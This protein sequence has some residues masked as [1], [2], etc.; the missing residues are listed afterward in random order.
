VSRRLAVTGVG[1]L[2]AAGAGRECLLCATASRARPRTFTPYPG[3]A[4][5]DGVWAASLPEPPVRELLPPRGT[6]A[7]SVEG[8]ALLC[9]AVLACREAGLPVPT[10][11]PRPLGDRCAGVALGTTRA[12]L[13]D[14]WRLFTEGVANGPDGMSPALGPRTG[15]NTPA[16][17][18][19]IML[20]AA[21][22]HL[23]VSSGAASAADAAGAAAGLLRRERAAA[24]LAGGVDV[25][26]S[27]AVHAGRALDPAY[28]T[29]REPRPFDRGRGGAA[30]GEAAV[31]LVLEDAADAARRGARCL[32]ELAGTGSAFDP[33]AGASGSVRAARR[34]VAEALAGAGAD[35]REVDAVVASASG[36]PG[37]DAVEAAAL[38][39][40]F[41]HRPPVCSV[42]GAVGDCAGAGSA[43]QLAA[44]VAALESQRVPATAGLRDRDPMLP[45]LRL[46]REPMAC[47]LGL[48]LVLAVD[49]AGYASAVL[50]RRAG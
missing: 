33:A 43:V 22:P 46:T 36:T 31:V 4:A 17:E 41:G 26:S 34:A 5:V 50:L 27:M 29:I 18:L 35:A 6:R 30:P 40:L 10:E 37:G 13:D 42:S 16:S 3:F 11:R 15:F 20:G 47:A 45:D 2:T 39:S 32:A 1:A 21:G 25:L 7:L 38:A 14:Y 9:A 24:M 8:R 28:G 48:V 49:P 23:S 12:G 44:A 19:S